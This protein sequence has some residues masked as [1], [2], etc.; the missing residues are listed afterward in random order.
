MG[1]LGLPIWIC[2]PIQ[3][4]M[5]SHMSL[6]CAAQMSSAHQLQ[7]CSILLLLM[8]FSNS[9]LTA[10]FLNLENE[11]PLKSWV[12]LLSSILNS[13]IFIFIFILIII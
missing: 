10:V 12:V 4:S 1:N 11:I 2:F 6:K 3:K 8:L 13:F 5:I 9:I 7:A